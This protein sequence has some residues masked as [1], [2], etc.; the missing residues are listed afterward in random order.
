[1]YVTEDTGTTALSRREKCLNS[2]PN[3]SAAP[4]FILKELTGRIYHGIVDVV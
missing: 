1:M 4:D 2:H 3:A